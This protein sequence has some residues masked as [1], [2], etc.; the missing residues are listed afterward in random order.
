MKLV[1]L[2]V[3]SFF[4]YQIE[5]YFVNKN[6]YFTWKSNKETIEFEFA[7]KCGNRG[8]QILIISNKNKFIGFSSFVENFK[9]FPS[10]FNP[11]NSTIPSS[12]IN[13]NE[14]GLVLN[15]ED[16]NIYFLRYKPDYLQMNVKLNST[17]F[18]KTLNLVNETVIIFI[19]YNLKRQSLNSTNFHQYIETKLHLFESSISLSF[20]PT[21]RVEYYMKQQLQS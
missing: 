16:K 15:Y 2:L 1:S 9:H 10:R 12:F 3:F 14:D 11:L 7:T 6:I 8:I 17:I 19:A 5:G 20:L 21:L 18:K 4:L 13:S